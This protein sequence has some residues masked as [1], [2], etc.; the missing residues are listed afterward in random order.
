MKYLKK[1]LY[2]LPLS[3]LLIF[4]GCR[5]EASF[6]IGIMQIV[7]HES[8]DSAR[9]GFTDELEK[10]GYE[11]GKNT[12]LDFQN[13][14]GDL[15]N[16]ASIAEKFAADRKNLILAISTPCAQACANA[17]KDIPVLATAITNFESTGL[18]ESSKV[19]GTNITGCSDLAPI[20]KSIELIVKLKPD[21]KK[22]GVLYSNLDASPQYQAELAEKKIK[23]L[24]LESRLFSVSQA[25]EIQAVAEELSEEV[26]ALYV[27][28]DKLTSSAMPQISKIFLDRGKFVVCA[29]NAMISK[30]AVATYGV[31]YYE[32]GKLTARQADKILKG[33]KNP[34]DMPIE[35]LTDTK[36]TLNYEIIKKLGLKI[37]D[38]LKGELL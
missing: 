31:D 38:E 21:V 23:D 12:E 6:K 20:G 25:Q 8:L 10:L 5:K 18:V 32:L 4:P 17:T 24:N 34:R 30:G 35:Y 22:I 11:D 33:E 2:L 26:D 9:K 3:L 13:A 37:S 15:S 36:L 14:G 28:V 7:E 29:E 1:T 27:P 16:C 19:P